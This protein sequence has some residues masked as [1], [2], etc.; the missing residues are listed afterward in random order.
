[1]WDD[2][3]IAIRR[4]SPLA[5]RFLANVIC[6]SLRFTTTDSR[7][8]RA[9]ANVM[10]W[11]ARPPFVQRSIGHKGMIVIGKT[12]MLDGEHAGIRAGLAIRHGA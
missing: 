12:K 10:R 1:M 4:I 8:T 2:E 9:Q 6:L 7:K 11:A 3:T 5:A